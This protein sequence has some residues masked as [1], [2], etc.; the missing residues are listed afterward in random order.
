MCVW[1]CEKI[2]EEKEKNN[3]H[4]PHYCIYMSFREKFANAL[5]VSQSV[6]III[7][8]VTS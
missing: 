2:N 6:R 4:V 3:G 7:L 5:I 8:L 1:M